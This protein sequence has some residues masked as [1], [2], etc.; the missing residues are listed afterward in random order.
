MKIKI[1][2]ILSIFTLFILG[3]S[4]DNV[5]FKYFFIITAVFIILINIYITIKTKK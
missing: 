5:F 3:F 4:T 1:I 2:T